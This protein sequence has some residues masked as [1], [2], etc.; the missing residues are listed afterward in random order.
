[1][2]GETNLENNWFTNGVVEVKEFLP[3]IIHDIAVI[4]LSS[5]TTEASAGE[6]V[7][8]DATVQNLGDVPESFN[9]TIYYD[10]NLVQTITIESLAPNTTLSLTTI[11]NTKNVEPDT[12]VLN[13]NVTILPNEVNIENNFF[14]DGQVSIRPN[15]EIPL[16]L[17]LIP[18]LI[19]LALIALLLLLLL[20]KRR[21]RKRPTTVLTYAILSHPHI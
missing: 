17:L 12:Y 3:S 5:N 11:W 10:A 9:L 2:P 18:F 13:A 20:L 7:T 1:V 6:N 4:G 21:R 8:I 15:Y 14:E 16:W 19:G